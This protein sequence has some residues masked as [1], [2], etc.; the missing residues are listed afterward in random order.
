MPPAGGCLT[1]YVRMATGT[2]PRP[3]VEQEACILMTDPSK[4]TPNEPRANWP[5]ITLDLIRLVRTIKGEYAAAV[6][7]LNLTLG[8]LRAADRARDRARANSA[9]RADANRLLHAEIT[10][11]LAELRLLRRPPPPP[12]APHSEARVQ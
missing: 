5:A 3:S 10:R 8:L 9:S 7:L 6:E 11:L 12:Q 1:L 2:T 4:L